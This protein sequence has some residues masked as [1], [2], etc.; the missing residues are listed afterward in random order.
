MSGQYSK[1]ICLQ[2]PQGGI[3]QLRC[4]SWTATIVE[5]PLPR[6]Y[7]DSD[8]Y[9]LRAGAVNSVAVY[10]AV[11]ISVFAAH[12]APDS[13]VIYPVVEIFLQDFKRGSDKLPVAA[14]EFISFHGLTPPLFPQGY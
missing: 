1:S 12:G 3:T 5:F 13:V 4:F 7:C 14:A 6:R 8:G 2:L 9:I 11:D 10:A